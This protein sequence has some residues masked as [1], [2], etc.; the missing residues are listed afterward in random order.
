M[1]IRQLILFPFLLFFKIINYVLFGKRRKTI[2]NNNNNN[3]NNLNEEEKIKYFPQPFV[4]WIWFL[5][6]LVWIDNIYGE[7]FYDE[8]TNKSFSLFELKDS[9]INEFDK[10]QLD[11]PFLSSND[12]GNKEEIE[13]IRK[14]I[15][16]F[17]KEC[18]EN[19]NLST[20][21]RILLKPI[22]I[23]YLKNRKR[24]IDFYI[25]NEEFIKKNSN[26]KQ[27]LIV[28]GLPRSGTTLL[29]R[30][31]SEDPKTRSPFTFELEQVTPPLLSNDDPM[32]DERIKTSA[33]GLTILSKLA[34]GFVEKFSESH[35]WSATEPEE[36]LIYTL[37]QNGISCINGPAATDDYLKE[38]L[39]GNK[40]KGVFKYEHRLFE[41]LDS[42]KHPSSHWTLKAPSYAPFIKETFEEYPDAK[43]IITHRNPLIT[44]PSVCR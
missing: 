9:L 13:N 11:H 14:L 39:D 12:W 24:L 8:I 28:T 38:L 20:F 35:L 4:K 41:M 36:S 44:I 5:K 37:T 33:A 34:P 19:E 15:I 1:N 40:V 6:P 21:G 26:F 32:K 7:L 42:Y 30:L 25:K 22:H 27:P 29:Q 23:G 10:S 43:L 3:N 31:L 2:Q 16:K 18:D 17:S